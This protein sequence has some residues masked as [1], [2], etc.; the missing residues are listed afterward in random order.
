MKI[1]GKSH[2]ECTKNALLYFLS[3][4]SEHTIPLKQ[5]SIA[6]FAIVAKDGLFW[7]SIVTSPQLLS[8]VT[9][10]RGTGSVMLYLSIVLARANTETEM[11]SFW[12]NFHHWLH[13]KLSKWQLPVQPVIKISS[14]WQHF[15]FSEVAQRRSSLVN[16]D[17]EYQCWF[18]LST[19]RGRDKMAA[20]FQTTFSNAFSW[21]KMH[22]YRL[23]FQWSLFLRFEFTIFQHWFR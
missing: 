13:W 15:R 11:S 19:H 23:R 1:I 14:K 12:W 10:T 6:Q 21:M 20:V 3:A 4:I 17:R 9:R 5:S 18:R 7:L 2:Q 16:N 22:E 8:E